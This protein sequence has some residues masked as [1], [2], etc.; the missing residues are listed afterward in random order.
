MS[1]VPWPGIRKL[2]RMTADQVRSL[3]IRA[4]FE[5]FKAEGP[6]MKEGVWIACQGDLSM[7]ALFRV[8]PDGRRYPQRFRAMLEIYSRSLFDQ[9]VELGFWSDGDWLKWHTANSVTTLDAFGVENP[10]D[11][12]SAK[13]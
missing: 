10:L 12:L 6:R 13:N 8:S 2:R 11:A 4:G 3:A 1:V 5:L 9:Q 7:Y